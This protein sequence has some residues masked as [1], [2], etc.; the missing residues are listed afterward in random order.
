MKFIIEEESRT[1]HGA[2]PSEHV[3]DNFVGPENFLNI[4]EIRGKI[5]F[6]TNIL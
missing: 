6:I 4:R 3:T 5:D 1:V 2:K